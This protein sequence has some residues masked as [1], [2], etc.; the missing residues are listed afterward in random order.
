MWHAATSSFSQRQG[1]LL[2]HF[3]Y[4]IASSMQRMHWPLLQLWL[5]KYLLILL[6]SR[7]GVASAVA[8]ALELIVVVIMHACNRRSIDVYALCILLS[9]PK[10]M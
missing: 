7:Q 6:Q 1:L 3:I 4:Y 2:M 9:T 10:K 8:A 5:C